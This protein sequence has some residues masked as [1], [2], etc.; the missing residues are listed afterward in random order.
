MEK[1][2]L[3]ITLGILCVLLNSQGIHKHIN[4]QFGNPKRFL[5]PISEHSNHCEQWPVI[6][7]KLSFSAKII[8]V[9]LLRGAV[10]LEYK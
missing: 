3:T 8:S 7:L 10:K 1:L 6:E 9:R 5:P 4:K 2:K